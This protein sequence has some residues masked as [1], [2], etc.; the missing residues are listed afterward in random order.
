[1]T[2]APH[3]NAATEALAGGLAAAA[4]RHGAECLVNTAGGLADLAPRPSRRRATA[5]LLAIGAGYIRFAVAEPGLFRT[6]FACTPP[7]GSAATDRA[8]AVLSGA[9]DDLAAAGG[10]PP[11]R[12]AHAEIAAW[13]AVHGTATLLIDGVGGPPGADPQPVIDRV[14]AMVIGGL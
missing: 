11:E 6:A 12:R 2:S 7:E 9:L 4:D 8:Y 5:R 1:M 14:S 10:L 13:A 3:G